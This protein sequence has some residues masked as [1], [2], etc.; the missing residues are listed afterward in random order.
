MVNL[1]S[2]III[3]FA[4]IIVVGIQAPSVSADE[5]SL[6]SAAATLSP[7]EIR[8]LLE[9]YNGGRSFDGLRDE[10]GMSVGH[11]AAYNI[12]HPDIVTL[13]DEFGTLFVGR[14]NQGRTPLA[15]GIVQNN[16]QF[17]WLVTQNTALWYSG[18]LDNGSGLDLCRRKLVH[19]E[20]CEVLLTNVSK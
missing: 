6:P 8:P 10:N 16:V 7:A 5:P 14:D 17:V 20:A 9:A 15:H 12:E 13:L 11:H 4:A 3:Q 19:N 2:R 1:S 18:E